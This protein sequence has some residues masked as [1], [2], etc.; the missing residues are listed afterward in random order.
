ML[1]IEGML[2][3]TLSKTG[4]PDLI[5]CNVDQY[6]CYDNDNGADNVS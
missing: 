3:M 1:M 2:Q 5:P 4:P 6:G